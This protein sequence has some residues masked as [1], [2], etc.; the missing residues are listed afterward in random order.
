MTLQVRESDL[1]APVKAYLQDYGF[2]VQAEVKDCDLVASKDGQLLIVEL[3][4]SI[5]L[6]LLI[7]ATTRQAITNSIYVAIPEIANRRSRQWRGTISI[8][9]RLELG[10]LL[11]TFGPLGSR[12]IRELDPPEG[13]QHSTP[14]SNIGPRNK[15]KL[16]AIEQ[17]LSGRSASYNTGG[18]NQQQLMTAYREN[19][20][21]IA[22]CLQRNGPLTT[23]A[24]RAIGTGDKTQKI[25]GDN[26]YGWF[27][28]VSRGVYCLNDKGL[29][30][31]TAY[32]ELCQLA[33]NLLDQM[34][35]QA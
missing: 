8:L 23:R 15:K 21:F 33:E 1:Y 30:A 27:N 19:A 26:H 4:K 34:N 17:E 12:I 29:Q 5:N 10:L 25:L 3:K 35:Q 24:L 20:I 11:V 14:D 6:T 18:V 22:C 16:R 7:Q 2:A 32:P 9:R 31:L 28:R 13:L